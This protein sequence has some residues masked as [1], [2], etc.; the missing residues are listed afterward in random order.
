MMI[1]LRSTGEKVEVVR[2]LPRGRRE[3]KTATG[4][5]IVPVTELVFRQKFGSK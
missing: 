1:T 5:K 3:I 4:R 2:I